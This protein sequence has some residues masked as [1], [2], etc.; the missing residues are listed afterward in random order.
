MSISHV[1]T[2]AWR[3]AG[4]RSGTLLV[5]FGALLSVGC[6]RKAEGAEKPQTVK[7]ASTASAEVPAPLPSALEFKELPKFYHLSEGSEFVPYCALKVF[8][9]ERGQIL[10]K[11]FDTYHLIPDQPSSEDNPLGLPIGLTLSNE[12]SFQLIGFNCAACHVGRIST[13]VPHTIVGAPASFNIR[14]FYDDVLPWIRDSLLKR[15]I[16]QRKVLGCMALEQL[17]RAKD[18]QGSAERAED[19]GVSEE[20]Q[21]TSVRDPNA[22]AELYQ[23][24]DE[25]AEK[26]DNAHAAQA[27]LDKASASVERASPKFKVS[28]RESRRATLGRWRTRYREAK[29][30]VL[31]FKDS[32]PNTLAVG[33]IEKTTRPGPGRVDAFMTA[34]NLMNSGAKLNMDS[35]VAFPPLW[36]LEH[37]VWLHFDG[38]TNA[39]LQRNMGQ[40]VGVGALLGHANKDPM[41]II[42]TT[43]N[44]KSL[45]ELEGLVRKIQPPSWPF[46]RPNGELVAE[47]ARVYRDNQCGRCHDPE[48]KPGEKN[49]FMREPSDDPKDDPNTDPL[50]LRNFEQR[51][52]VITKT[53]GDLPL[54]KVLGATLAKVEIASGA[55]V[56]ERDKNPVWR[57]TGKYAYRPLKG[58]WATA[59]YLH[60]NSV[61]TLADL[62]L[63]PAERPKQFTL[64]YS[65]YDTEAV[66]FEQV[67]EPALASK[68]SS[69]G[70]SERFDTTIAGNSNRGHE[71]GTALSLA[72]KKA[73]LAYLKQL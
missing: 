45:R 1:V 52:P 8:A 18:A 61:P 64:D 68:P 30:L 72:D 35:P 10:E 33:A 28:S 66:G 70:P 50:R 27:E 15:T 43:L 5:V 3:F 23:H 32:L 38:N 55:S 22:A 11:F 19:D 65:H 60:N 57:T 17:K 63:P 24:L 39:T 54:I 2:S 16:A 44:I 6:Q 14:Q 36:G 31:A 51:D 20:L 53:W 34:L 42:A 4:P 46:A 41:A 25:A 71:F 49:E 40:A 58:V 37:V 7:V 62:L 12:K 13:D 26:P 67:P 21:A 59:P 69:S 48:R 29:S 47:G 56:E 73:V 9:A